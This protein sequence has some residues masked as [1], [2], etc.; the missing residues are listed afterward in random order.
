MP[1]ID[2]VAEALNITG[3]FNMQLIAKDGSVKIIETNLRASRSAPFSSKTIGTDLIEVAT[4]AMLHQPGDPPI[5][6]V[7]GLI[8]FEVNTDGTEGDGPYVGIKSPM[9]SWKR[10]LGADPTLGV[11]M[12][13]TGEVACYGRNKHESFLLSLLSTTFPMPEKKKVLVSIEQTLR[14]DF[15]RS[16][17]L[18][19]EQDYEIYATEKTA[20]FI[21]EQ[22]NI[23]VTMLHWL[24]SNQSPSI[25]E[26]CR[27]KEIDLCLMFANSMSVRTEMNYDIRRLV[28]DFNIPLITN[29]QVAE[30]FAEA[31]QKLAAGEIELEPL[32][33]K[34]HY[35]RAGRPL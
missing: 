22:T 35:A 8:N 28:S 5:E 31:T 15:T 11:E 20:E 7:E 1:T 12:A 34:E 17:E 3:P 27:N 32:H 14:S 25:E 13:S 26:V 21:N 33:L 30:L 9:F 10:L 18:L 2:K 19:H 6:D 23:P 29:L 4:K 16:L 24:G